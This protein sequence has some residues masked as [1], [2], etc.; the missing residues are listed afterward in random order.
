M[1]SLPCAGQV[2]VWDILV[3]SFHWSLVTL[4]V[5]C[6]LSGDD[7]ETLHVYLGYAIVILLAV[8]IVWGVIGTRYARFSNFIYSWKTLKHYGA[9]LFTGG[10]CALPGH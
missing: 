3:R 10:R 4:F 1:N 7:L 2:K 6:Y 9:G 8:R 5:L